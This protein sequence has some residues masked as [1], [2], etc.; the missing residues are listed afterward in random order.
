MRGAFESHAFNNDVFSFK[1]TL[2]GTSF[3]VLINLAG[4]EHTVN[5]NDFNFND[6]IYEE[7]EVVLAGSKSSYI[8]G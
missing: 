2:D 8:A 7:S 6:A 3:I 5:V 1:R 4:N